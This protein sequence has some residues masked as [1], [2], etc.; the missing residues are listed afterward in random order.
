M[1]KSLFASALFLS[2]YA[3]GQ[4][5]DWDCN[6]YITYTVDMCYQYST[7]YQYLFKCNGTSSIVLYYY[8]DGDCST[9]GEGAYDSLTYGG[10]SSSYFNCDGDD[11]CSYMILRYYYDSDC[12]GDSYY[13]APF[14]TGECYT[15]SGASGEYSCSGSKYT[16]TAYSS[17]DCSGSSSSASITIDDSYNENW[18]GCYEVYYML[19]L[20]LYFYFYFLAFILFVYTPR[21]KF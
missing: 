18:S 7:S 20:C 4:A 19:F 11:A 12:T 14:I 2:S 21:K 6:H 15:G 3:Y 1:M 16:V 10:S 8:T 17:D 13:D 5:Y 9:D